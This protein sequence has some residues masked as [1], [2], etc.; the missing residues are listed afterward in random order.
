MAE[1]NQIIYSHKEL[2]TL[3]VKDRGIH[4]GWW[5]VYL[6]FAIKGANVGANPGTLLPAAI[7]PVLEI[8]LQKF[9]EDTSL[10]V[11]AAEVNPVK[12]S[13][14]RSKKARK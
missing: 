9:D 5:G 8:G 4:E 2:A 6:K 11:D 14:V 7:V 10:S 3:M 12:E 13:R 1:A